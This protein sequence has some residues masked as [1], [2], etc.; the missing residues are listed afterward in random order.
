MR[1]GRDIDAK[2]KTNYSINPSDWSV[3]KQKP[4]NLNDEDFKK[5]DENLNIFKGKLLNHFNNSADKSQIGS[6]WLKNFINPPKQEAEIPNK[7]VEYFDYYLLHKK[8]VIAKASFTKYNVIKHLIENFQKEMKAVYLIKDVNA[9]FKLNF[10]KYCLKTANYSVNT[11]SRGF[12]FV[13]TIC[14]DARS[15]G[16]ET[17]HQLSKLTT[18]NEKVQ[19]IFLTFEE[20]EIITKNVF[21]SEHLANSRDWLVISCETG[22]RVSD[23]LNFTKEKIRLVEIVKQNKKVKVSLLEFTQ[24]KTKKRMSVPLNKKV[25]NILNKRGGEFPNKLSSQNYN[26]HIKEICEMVGLTKKI[27]GSKVNSETKRKESGFFPKFELVTS[28]I[29][30]RSF[31]TNYYGKIPTSLLMYATGHST[32]KMFLEYIGKTEAEKAMQLAEYFI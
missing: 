29:G 15:N 32:E 20:L 9:D 25:L 23:F 16:I 1:D 22:Q 14:Y 3:A 5:L 10:E 18:K 19:K 11:F 21:T 31:A 28:H 26:Q 6:L 4:K 24:V 17:H 27:N 12:R 30:R 13:K 2:A 7:L 8:S